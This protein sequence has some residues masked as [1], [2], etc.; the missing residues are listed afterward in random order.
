M[1]TLSPCLTNPNT[2]RYLAFFSFLR[3]RVPAAQTPFRL[4][5]RTLFLDLPA[6]GGELNHPCRS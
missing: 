3:L 6:A 2:V 5:Q 4:L 1:D